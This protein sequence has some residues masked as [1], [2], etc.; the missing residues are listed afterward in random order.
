MEFAC[1]HLG[2]NLVIAQR[3]RALR[4]GQRARHKETN[5]YHTLH[6]TNLHERFF[7]EGTQREHLCQ[8]PTGHRHVIRGFSSGP[9]RSTKNWDMMPEVPHMHELPFLCPSIG[10]DILL[11]CRTALCRKKCSLDNLKAIFGMKR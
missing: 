9:V 4:K 6:N 2:T 3:I 1:R 8:G 11:R 10:I 5:T 7:N